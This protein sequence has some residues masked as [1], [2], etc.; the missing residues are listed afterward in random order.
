MPNRTPEE[1]AREEIDR[2][3]GAIGKGE[4]CPEITL[5]SQ[6]GVGH[7]APSFRRSVVGMLRPYT[8][9]RA[10]LSRRDPGVGVA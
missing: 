9:L 8:L 1:E 7:E 6:G 3:P 2:Y 10:V 4:A 5:A